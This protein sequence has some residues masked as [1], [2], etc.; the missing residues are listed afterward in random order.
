MDGDGVPRIA[1]LSG[2]ELARARQVAVHSPLPSGAGT[3]TWTITVMTVDKIPLAESLVTSP[4][5]PIPLSEI[6]QPHLDV[7]GLVAAGSWEP[8]ATPDGS[9]RFNAAVRVRPGR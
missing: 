1:R 8:Q 5:F 9:P 3:L 2:P 7:V 6:V 4:D